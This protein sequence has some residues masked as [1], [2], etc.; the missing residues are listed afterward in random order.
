MTENLIFIWIPKVAGTSIFHFFGKFGMRNHFRKPLPKMI[1]GFITINHWGAEALMKKKIL[2]KEYFSRAFKFCFVRNPWDRM[3]SL[4]FYLKRE[5]IFSIVEPQKQITFNQFVE[6]VKDGVTGLTDEVP[7]PGFFHLH[8]FSQ[9]YP[10]AGWIFD[11]NGKI[12]VDFVGR[13]EQLQEN[14][15][16]LLKMIG[17]DAKN[18]TLP[19]HNRTSHR[20][21]HQYYDDYSRKMVAN[22]YKQDIELFKYQ[23]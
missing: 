14:F 19:Y 18:L 10:Q 17:S 7:Y 16:T 13:Y 11:E 5:G 20:S 21:Y 6:R 15:N 2:N 23:F 3:V 8:K 12:I 22:I 9:C 4:Y 1:H